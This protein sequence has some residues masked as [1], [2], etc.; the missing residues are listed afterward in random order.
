MVDTVSYVLV[1]VTAPAQ[2]GWY[3]LRLSQ[4]IVRFLPFLWGHAILRDSL[5]T[6]FHIVNQRFY[7]DITQF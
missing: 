3:I 6:R 1:S 5:A 2:K 4:V 7:I